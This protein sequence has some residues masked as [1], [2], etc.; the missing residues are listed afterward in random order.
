MSPAGGLSSGRRGVVPG[1]E[2]R[3]HSH[4]GLIDYKDLAPAIDDVAIWRKFRETKLA[5]QGPARGLMAQPAT[6]PPPRCESPPSF[7]KQL[8]PRVQVN[9]LRTRI[10]SSWSH[11]PG[12]D[13][14][15]GVINTDE[16][17]VWGAGPPMALTGHSIASSGADSTRVGGSRSQSPSH[18]FL[19]P[20]QRSRKPGFSFLKGKKPPSA[21]DIVTGTTDSDKFFRRLQ[22][23]DGSTAIV[24][25]TGDTRLPTG[26]RYVPAWGQMHSVDTQLGLNVKLLGSQGEAAA[27]DG[28]AQDEARGDRIH[29]MS[30]PSASRGRPVTATEPTRPPIKYNRKNDA[31]YLQVKSVEGTRLGDEAMNNVP[32]GTAGIGIKVSDR[33]PVISPFFRPIS[34]RNHRSGGGDTA[35]QSRNPSPLDFSV[36]LQTIL[37]H[38]FGKDLTDDL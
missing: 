13:D 33:F 10:D 31:F 22:L 29:T 9:A 19:S 14:S 23:R 1:L 20:I 35:G 24:P 27:V 6:R 38:D 34:V 15:W 16:S 4:S 12:E 25:V 30:L 37:S 28:R 21:L 3:S 11:F 17:V 18:A 32:P 36:Q 2:M 8:P 26:A 5:K 7:F